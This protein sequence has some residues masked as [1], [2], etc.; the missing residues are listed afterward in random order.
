MPKL[1][2]SAEKAAAIRV[3]T[4]PSSDDYPDDADGWHAAQ[5]DWLERWKPGT[6]LPEPAD[7][8]RRTE[9]NKLTKQHERHLK[10]AEDEPPGDVTMTDQ[11]LLAEADIT[12]ADIVTSLSYQLNEEPQ[13]GFDLT[14]DLAR[15]VFDFVCPDNHHPKWLLACKLVCKSW[16]RIVA[17][18]DEKWQRILL[19]HCP[20]ALALPSGYDDAHTRCLRLAA[21][22]W[23][24]QSEQV[25]VRKLRADNFEVVVAL[26]SGR[27]GEAPKV[28]WSQVLQLDEA[29]PIDY[30]APGGPEPPQGTGFQ[31]GGLE[32]PLLDGSAPKTVEELKAAVEAI[33][34]DSARFG[35]LGCD[36]T[37][38]VILRRKSDDKIVMCGPP[39]RFA[40]QGCKLILP[41]PIPPPQ[42]CSHPRPTFAP[43]VRPIPP[44]TLPPRM[45]DPHRACW[46]GWDAPTMY[47]YPERLP[48]VLQTSS[49]DG[50]PTPNPTY[51]RVVIK[52]AL[53]PAMENGEVKWCFA[54]ELAAIGDEDELNSYHPN[55]DVNPFWQM[56][57]NLIYQREDWDDAEMHTVTEALAI[58]DWK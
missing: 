49:G 27:G 55:P 34:A 24:P 43:R 18:Y 50:G 52:P 2:S 57:V 11:D 37:L 1:I 17:H 46:Q 19:A 41:P 9:W 6:A 51:P 33:H 38:S 54:L 23:P 45:H 21:V 44:P 8:K 15:I 47:F 31:W 28:E 5:N 13:F 14:V 16:R 56:G 58:A 42:V 4:P 25:H 26:L 12:A 3:G 30:P 40:F 22:I 29:A 53:S 20:A 7:R 48:M 32:L 10:A 36:R 35:R 39:A